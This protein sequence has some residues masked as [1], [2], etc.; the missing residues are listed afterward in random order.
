MS[1]NLRRTILQT[2]FPIISYIGKVHAPW[3]HRKLTSKHY[4]EIKSILR[5]GDAILVHK[6]GELSNIFIP[7]FWTHGT[8]FYGQEGNASIVIEAIGRGVVKTDLIDAILSRDAAIVCRPKFAT[9][10]QSA[11]ASD[12]AKQ[13]IGKS[14]DLFFN[15]NND[16]F[17]CS[18]LIWLAYQ[19]TMGETPF[20]LKLTL[21]VPT[22]TPEDIVNATKKWEI[23]YDSRG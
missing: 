9:A 16:A 7:G 6:K 22:V 5:P 21:G 20:T 12:W 1:F 3:S 15:P 18:E 10:E 14:Y 2:A 11:T 4:R 23:I 17:Y 8:I 19:N 13:Q